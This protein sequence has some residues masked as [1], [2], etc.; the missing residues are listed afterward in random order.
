MLEDEG[1]GARRA[2][3]DP[4]TSGRSDSGGIGRSLTLYIRAIRVHQW[5]KNSLVFVPLLLAH[6]ITDLF[7][8][9]DATIGFISFS[10]CASS[11]YLLNDLLD[12]EADR[13]HPKKRNRP[14]AA[15]E[16][17][18]RATVALIPVLLVGSFAL[19]ALLPLRFLATLSLYLLLT[20]SY[21]WILKRAVLVDVL[22]LAGLYTLR[23]I[24]G[25][26]AT[27]TPVSFWLLAFSMFLFL[28][29]ALV[30]RFG[31]LLNLREVG[32]DRAVGRGY[33]AV[34]L[35]TLTQ[36]GTA[37]A[38]LSVLVLAL[39]VES[40]AVKELYARPEVIWLLCPMVLYL[41]SRI[42]LLARRGEIDEDPLLFLLSDSRSVGIALLGLFL[43]WVAA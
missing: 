40:D 20:I 11:A 1:R 22:V 9:L 10:L 4:T 36:F 26:A 42:W 41:T 30:K 15:G 2:S 17:S 7:A 39:Y 31:E 12:L 28:S 32:G 27:S 43:L 33:Q 6:Q 23:I 19:A 38:Y 8:L 35:E 18:R 37:S 16:I 5:I 13:Q 34:D 24:A 29:L 25:G 3:E 21:S 14:L